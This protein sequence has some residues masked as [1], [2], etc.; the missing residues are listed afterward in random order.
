VVPVHRRLNVYFI[1]ADPDESRTQVEQR[2][3]EL[4]LAVRESVTIPLAV[5]IG[6]YFS[7]MANMA[8]D[9]H[10]HR[11]RNLAPGDDLD[12]P[13]EPSRHDAPASARSSPPS[14]SITPNRDDP[15]QG[16]RRGPA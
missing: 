2:Y 14:S 5:K 4:V 15:H 8:G 1:V 3:L 6:P 16:R 13:S 11:V 9:H 10:G 12:V 7:S